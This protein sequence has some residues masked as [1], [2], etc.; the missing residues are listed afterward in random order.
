LCLAARGLSREIKLKSS[1]LPSC[2]LDRCIQSR[3]NKYLLKQGLDLKVWVRVVSNV[4]KTTEIKRGMKELY[5][6]GGNEYKLSE[7]YPYRYLKAR[8]FIFVLSHF[9]IGYCI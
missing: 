1:L 7:S 9:V 6:D 2:V 4:E 8:Q 5:V 3:I